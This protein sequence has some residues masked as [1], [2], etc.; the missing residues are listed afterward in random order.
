MIIYHIKHILS[1]IFN[2]ISV[3]T[4]PK[5]GLWGICP[6]LLVGV[7]IYVF[8]SDLKEE[9]ESSTTDESLLDKN[10]LSIE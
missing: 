4:S 10:H 6:E 9:E 7:L 2:S 1:T 5:D 8:T 3:H